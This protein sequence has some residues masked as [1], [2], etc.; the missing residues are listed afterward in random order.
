[1]KAY[2]AQLTPH[3]W[4][5]VLAEQL[6]GKNTDTVVISLGITTCA[7]GSLATATVNIGKIIIINT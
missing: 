4:T 5:E 1:V 6:E 7:Y 2:L 3:G